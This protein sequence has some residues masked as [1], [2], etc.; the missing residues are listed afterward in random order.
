MNLRAVA[1]RCNRK[2][3]LKD[4]P[5]NKKA[6]VST[7]AAFLVSTGA[8]G[9]FL[10]QPSVTFAADATAEAP[11]PSLNGTIVDTAGKLMAGVVLEWNSPQQGASFRTMTAPDGAFRI[12]GV[13][14]TRDGSIKILSPAGMAFTSQ[15]GSLGGTLSPRS[16]DNIVYGGG[17]FVE[18]IKIVVDPAAAL[19]PVEY[20]REVNRGYTLQPIADLALPKNK[21]LTDDL[22]PDEMWDN[23]TVVAGRVE[24]GKGNVV[25]R[26]TVN[27]IQ[28]NGST[29]WTQR[30]T[31]ALD[32]EFRFGDIPSGNYKL[33]VE[34]PDGIKVA[35][36]AAPAGSGTAG[37]N[38]IDG[39]SIAANSVFKGAVVTVDLSAVKQPS[40]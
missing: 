6:I 21:R 20:V 10:T 29:T 16:I 35:K 17:T 11:A 27:L 5:M 2:I 25:G 38:S 24:D 26:V 33:I 34:G 12:A 37:A 1:N 40:Q 13:T 23:K 28:V 22:K 9:M 32:G 14:N 7:A 15:T 31:S 8:A 36:M 30:Q 4:F 3:D 39:I 19:K 18:G